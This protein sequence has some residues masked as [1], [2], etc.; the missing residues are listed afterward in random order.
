MRSV[1]N[2]ILGPIITEKALEMK[3]VRDSYGRDGNEAQVVVLR[4]APEATKTEI[5][6][7]VQKIFGVKV[8]SVRTINM[9]GKVKRVGRY[10]GRR[11]AWKKA[12]VTVAAGEKEIVFSV[13]DGIALEVFIKLFRG[14]VQLVSQVGKI[15]APDCHVLVDARF[16]RCHFEDAF[17]DPELGPVN[18]W[19]ALDFLEHL[20]VEDQIDKRIGFRGIDLHLVALFEIHSPLTGRRL[21]IS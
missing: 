21:R 14:D 9:K 5:R 7:A 3:D 19:Q 11:N 8:A 17:I 1:W 12:Y 2:V 20:E 15:L 16:A 10:E 13:A 6:E 4:V 18:A